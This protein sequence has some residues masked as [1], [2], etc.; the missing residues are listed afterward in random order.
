MITLKINGEPRQ[1]PT[2]WEDLTFK[3]YNILLQSK[4]ETEWTELI[5]AWLEIDYD[6]FQNATLIGFEPVMASM[7]FIT[8]PPTWGAENPKRVREF[9]LPENITLETVIQYEHM[10][11]L[12]LVNKEFKD[13]V[14]DYPMIVAIYC[15]KAMDGAYNYDKARDLA[16]EFQNANAREIIE[17]GNFFLV[18]LLSLNNG[19]AANSP[20]K[21]PTPVKPKSKESWASSALKRFST[22]LPKHAVKKKPT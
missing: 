7:H 18:K 15:Q 22:M 19:S 21:S 16:A 5:A 3:Q 17:A 11:K 20:S 12:A 6:T 9:I 1:M 10:K 4:L 8:V 13:K 14:A 2:C